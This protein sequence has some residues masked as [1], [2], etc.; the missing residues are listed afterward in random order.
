MESKNQQLW[1]DKSE[2]LIVDDIPENLQLLGQILDKNNIDVAIA[3]NGREAIEA[4]EF[5][6][7]D[8]ILL[9]ISMPEMDGFSVCRELKGNPATRHIPV[10]FLSA[11]TEYEDIVK[12][13]EIGAVDY[14]TKPFN[15]KEL[16]SRVFTHL[17]LSFSKKYIEKQN[18]E[19]H[20][21]NATKD[22][23][24]SIIAHDLKNP[25]SGIIGLSNILVNEYK[26]LDKDTVGEYHELILDSA[27]KGYR[28]LENLLNWSSAQTGRLEYNPQINNLQ[29]FIKEEL[30]LLNTNAE[31]KNIKLLAE[32]PENTF[33]F[34]DHNMIETVIRNLVS[35]AIKFTK[36]G[37]SVSIIASNQD[38]MVQI[39]VKDNGVGISDEDQKKLFR[40]DVH[41]STS[42]TNNEE[43]TGLGLV[44]CKEF[45]EKNG[46][47]I[48]VESVEG[49]G[50][51]FIFTLNKKETF[52][53]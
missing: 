5:S 45:V 18:N 7:P 28:L 32:V 27:E 2:V 17:E 21:L 25:F 35:N 14:V 8:L 3:T 42:G 52:E 19:L 41:H 46:G 40:V 51:R 20:E 38:E 11:R 13:F 16:L 30:Q 39:E 4:V 12:G 34:F 31:Q 24:F 47:K 1:K 36:P 22:K 26:D 49:R 44:L 43:G 33:A 29:C 6:Q 48:R 10:I 53:S 15:A 9:D 50:S 37:G 23:F